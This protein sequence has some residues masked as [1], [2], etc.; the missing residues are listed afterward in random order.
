[1]P[2]ETSIFNEI[3][4]PGVDI[5]QQRAAEAKDRLNQILQNEVFSKT[6]REMIRFAVGD[7]AEARVE[8]LSAKVGAEIAAANQL[9]YEHDSQMM[10]LIIAP[11]SPQ[12]EAIRA[13]DRAIF[14][15]IQVANE[16]S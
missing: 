13:K 12:A 5:A 10:T 1:M 9:S 4:G 2:F 15:E 3:T 8:I 11:D 16:G 14:A 7:Y 6:V